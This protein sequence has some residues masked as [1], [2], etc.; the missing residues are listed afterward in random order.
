VSMPP[1]TLDD[2][3]G[4]IR[5]LICPNCGETYL[6]QTDVAIFHRVEDGDQVKVTTITEDGVHE[7]VIANDVSLNPSSRRHGLRISFWCEHCDGGLT[8]EERE[9]GVTS[10]Q[11]PDLAIYQHKGITF[12]EWV[13]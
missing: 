11:V 9:N 2:Y 4:N 12:I 1:V 10:N 7:A 6:H 3:G 8:D 13:K 5:G